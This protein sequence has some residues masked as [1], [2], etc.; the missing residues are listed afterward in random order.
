MQLVDE[1]IFQVNCCLIST[2]RTPSDV[3]DAAD[4]RG[5]AVAP[6]GE[7]GGAGEALVHHDGAFEHRLI[8]VFAYLL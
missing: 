1:I 3:Q 8:N 4:A 6:D 5:D 7:Q 2:Q